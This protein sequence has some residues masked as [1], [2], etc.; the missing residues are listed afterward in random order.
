MTYDELVDLALARVR[1]AGRNVPRALLLRRIGQAQAG[2]FAAAA[3][4]NPE[5][6]G[7][8]VTAA[9]T[10]GACDL[11][12]LTPPLNQAAG[13]QRIEVATTDASPTAPPVGAR[14]SIVALAAIESALAPRATLRDN[15]LRQVGTELAGVTSVKVHYA[16][17]SNPVRPT[18]GAAEAELREPW[19]ELLTLDVAG[20]VL[21]L[22][23]AEGREVPPGL[24]AM[25]AQE[26]GTLLLNYQAHVRGYVEDVED[27]FMRAGGPA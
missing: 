5:Y 17:L 16:R 4:W 9:L 18:D 6:Y 25:V 21:D 10:G 14:V 19:Q 13:I 15:V 27:R 7:I 20:Y 22:L 11:N 3:T 8:C 12:A 26:Y 24:K 2:L 23:V 1:D